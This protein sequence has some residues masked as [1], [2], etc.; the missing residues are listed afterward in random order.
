MI[1]RV[2]LIVEDDEAI[3]T[4]IVDAINSETGYQ[5]ILATDGA[6]ALELTQSMQVD[7]FLLDIGLPDMTGIELHDRVR[8][9][10][11]F[12]HTPVLFVS[13]S[14]NEH[15]KEL[16]ARGAATFLPKPFELGALLDLVR[17]LAPA[18]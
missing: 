13:A 4:L 9:E 15:A 5:A 17:W 7:L 3:G 18:A 2:V 1:P 10:D 14:T 11:R 6:I 16:A 8:A 12:R